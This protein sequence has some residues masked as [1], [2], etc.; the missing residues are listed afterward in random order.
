MDVVAHGFLANS[1]GEPHCAID[2]CLND[3]EWTIAAS[4]QSM[5]E[6]ANLLTHYASLLFFLNR[7]LVSLHGCI[8]NLL[9]SRHLAGGSRASRFRPDAPVEQCM[10]DRLRKIVERYPDVRTGGAREIDATDAVTL[11]P[12]LLHAIGIEDLPPVRGQF[13][14]CG[15]YSL[16][17]L[18]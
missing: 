14:R 4:K 5:G 3:D 8:H 13:R 1:A 7:N 9:P 11:R 17:C 15:I 2:Q 18:L 10:L 16:G 6:F 12:K